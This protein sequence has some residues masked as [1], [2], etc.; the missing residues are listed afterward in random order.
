MAKML[1]NSRLLRDLAVCR[2]FNVM[3]LNVQYSLTPLFTLPAA[4]KDHRMRVKV[5]RVKTI[6][7]VKK[8]SRE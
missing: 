8:T 2:G 4:A 1:A 7:R 5:T 3:F 6:S